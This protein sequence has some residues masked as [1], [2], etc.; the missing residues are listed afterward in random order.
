[1][2]CSQA[3]AGAGGTFD[4]HVFMQQA[5]AEA[6]AECGGTGTSE[7]DF[8]VGAYV[9]ITSST[10]SCGYWHTYRDGCCRHNTTNECA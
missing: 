5:Q 6:D 7:Y 3:C 2:T 8:S 1:M 10:T 9:C 4:P